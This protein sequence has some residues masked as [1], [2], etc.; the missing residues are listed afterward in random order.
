MLKMSRSIFYKKNK[1]GGTPLDTTLLVIMALSLSVGTL[2]VFYMH[3]G[4]VSSKIQ[5]S[6][7][8]DEIYNRENKINFYINEMMGKSI[9]KV[10]NELD[11]VPEFVE[12]MKNELG[13]YKTNGTYLMPELIQIENQIN[14]ENIQSI[15]G[16]IIFSVN[17]NL[18][19]DLDK[20][21][22]NYDY[23]KRFILSIKG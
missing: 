1:K 6:R 19:Q 22:S 3:S 16:N 13:K 21:S 15:D 17:I 10:K 12:Y 8:L 20:F 5:D 14:A 4:F 23:N 9:L 11:P 7:F 2:F 18:K